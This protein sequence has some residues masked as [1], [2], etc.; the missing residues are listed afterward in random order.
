M[1]P[2]YGYEDMD[3]SPLTHHMSVSFIDNHHKSSCN[4]NTT[5]LLII[6]NIYLVTSPTRHGPTMG[7]QE[8][9]I[10]SYSI[11]SNAHD[12]ISTISSYLYYYRISRSTCCLWDDDEVVKV[13]HHHQQQQAQATMYYTF[14]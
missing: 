8:I 7:I 3:H 10:K 1:L 6:D 12:A 2:D 9:L 5:S 13:P 11:T 14:I 4:N